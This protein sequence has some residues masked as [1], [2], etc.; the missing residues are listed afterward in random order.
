MIKNTL[1]KS[2]FGKKD[3]IPEGESSE[4]QQEQEEAYNILLAHRMMTEIARGWARVK[5]LKACTEGHIFASKAPYI[6]G[7]IPSPNRTK[8]ED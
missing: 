5:I 1:T 6:K 8:N 2:N 7:S 4:R 3:F